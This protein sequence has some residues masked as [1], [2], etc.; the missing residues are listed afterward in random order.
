M[1]V[2]PPPLPPVRRATSPVRDLPGGHPCPSRVAA[3]GAVGVG[4]AGG[5][6][7]VAGVGDVAAVAVAADDA[8]RRARAYPCPRTV[9]GVAEGVAVGVGGDGDVAV[10]SGAPDW[11]VPTAAASVHRGGAGGAWS[12]DGLP[13]SSRP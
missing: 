13:L 1:G 6:A 3:A 8:P 4:V 7:G 5:A 11:S 12:S 10:S 2:G 9:A